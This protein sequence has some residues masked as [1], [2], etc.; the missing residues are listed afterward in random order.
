MA[1]QARYLIRTKINIFTVIFQERAGFCYIA[2]APSVTQHCRSQTGADRRKLNDLE[3]GSAPLMRGGGPKKISSQLKKPLLDPSTQHM[4]DLHQVAQLV[5]TA[6][7]PSAL[8]ARV[9][10]VWNWDWSTPAEVLLNKSSS[11]SLASNSSAQPTSFTPC[12]LSL[13]LRL[14][15]A[16]SIN[17]A[18][19]AALS[20]SKPQA[21]Q[22]ESHAPAVPAFS[23]FNLVFSAPSSQPGEPLSLN[24]LL[25]MLDKFNALHIE[26]DHFNDSL[27]EYTINL[28]IFPRLASLRI[29]IPD[30]HMLSKLRFSARNR[31]PSI[32]ALTISSI[33]D[34]PDFSLTLLDFT[35]STVVRTFLDQS[36]IPCLNLRNLNLDLPLISNLAPSLANIRFLDLSQ[37]CISSFPLALDQLP[38][39]TALSLASNRLTSF[40]VGGNDTQNSNVSFKCLSHLSLSSNSIEVIA[41]FSDKRIFPVLRALDLR[42]NNLDDVLQLKGCS[43]IESL[44]E[45]L[46][47]GNP[48]A[49][50]DSHRLNIFTYFG[51]RATLLK[52]DGQTPTQ[53]E[54]KEILASLTNAAS[55]SSA[56]RVNVKST[57]LHTARV[58]PSDVESPTSKLLQHQPQQPRQKKPTGPGV[59][60][61]KSKKP[62]VAIVEDF[63]VVGM[64][65]LA[66]TSPLPLRSAEGI[67]D[68][69]T[70]YMSPH[71]NIGKLAMYEEDGASEPLDLMMESMYSDERSCTP[72]SEGNAG[73]NP[74]MNLMMRTASTSDNVMLDENANVGD[75]RML[76]KSNE[77]DIPLQ[78]DAVRLYSGSSVSVVG[79]TEGQSDIL[80]ARPVG[81]NV[82]ADRRRAN[83]GKKISRYYDAP[84]DFVF[85]GGG[86]TLSVATSDDEDSLT[87]PLLHYKTNADAGTDRSNSDASLGTDGQRSPVLGSISGTRGDRS[88]GNGGISVGP[89]PLRSMSSGSD[90][91]L[92]SSASADHSRSLSRMDKL[93]RSVAAATVSSGRQSPQLEDST[94]MRRNQ[95]HTAK[96]NFPKMKAMGNPFATAKAA[97]SNDISKPFVE[98][99][100]TTLRQAETA[101]EWQRKMA[102][103]QEIARK[104]TQQ[105]AASISSNSDGVESKLSLS[106]DRSGGGG[107]QEALNFTKSAG[108]TSLNP[109]S[110]LFNSRS[111]TIGINGGVGAASGSGT[112]ALD[113][114][115]P[116]RRVYE[117][118]PTSRIRDD[119][120][121]RSRPVQVTYLEGATV[122]SPAASGTSG[123]ERGSEPGDLNDFGASSG[124]GTTAVSGGSSLPSKRENVVA[125]LNQPLS[126]NLAQP[127]ALRSPPVRPNE[128]NFKGLPRHTIRSGLYGN[129][130]G[131][132]SGMDLAPRLIL[133]RPVTSNITVRRSHQDGSEAGSEMSGTAS[134]YS[135]FQQRQNAANIRT[136]GLS[137][138]G[139]VASSVFSGDSGG[140]SVFSGMTGRTTGSA[141][142]RNYLLNHGSGKPPA[143]ALVFPRAPNVPFLSINN[144]LQLHLK[145]NVF[146]NDQEKI[147]AWVAGSI[148]PQVSPYIEGVAGGATT[149]G[150]R[151]DSA[152]SASSF[153]MGTP[154]VT[155][156]AKL[157]AI[158]ERMQTVERAGYILLTDKAIYL[159]TPTF[160]MPYNPFTGSNRTTPAAAAAA[161]AHLSNVI[162]QVRYDDPTRSLK[163]ARKIPLTH[164]ARVDVG[165]N[166][167]YMGIHF[168]A[169]DEKANSGSANGGGGGA[170]GGGGGGIGVEASLK[171]GGGRAV[172]S[173][174]T[175]KL[176]LSGIRSIVFLTRDRTATSRVLD[177]LVPLL[178]ESTGRLVNSKFNLKGADGKVKVV[179][180]D[181]EWSLAALRSKVLLKQTVAT[182]NGRGGFKNVV[183]NQ[184]D[185]DGRI[186]WRD[187]VAK[188]NGVEMEPP[189]KKSWLSGIL[190]NGFTG[191]S[192]NSVAAEPVQSLQ[193]T[194]EILNEDDLDK[195]TTNAV[196]LDK[197][198]FEFLKLYLLV[199]WIVPHKQAPPTATKSK[200][201]PSVTVTVNSVTLVAT[202]E[203]IYLT[204][205]RFDAWPPPLFPLSTRPAAHVNSPFLEHAAA[206]AAAKQRGLN[207]A[208]RPP[209]PDP[210]QG[211]LAPEIN[212][213]SPPL[214]V[215]RVCDLVRCERWKTWR[216]KLGPHVTQVEEAPPLEQNIA[217]LVQNGAIGIVRAVE[218]EWPIG[219]GS[220]SSSSSSSVSLEDKKARAGATSGWEWWVRVVFKDCESAEGQ[221]NSASSDTPGPSSNASSSSMAGERTGS[222]GRHDSAAPKEYFWDLVFSTL[223]AANEFLEFVK[224]VR[225]VKPVHET[226]EMAISNGFASEEEEEK[227]VGTNEGANA[228]EPFAADFPAAKEEFE[229][230]EFARDSRLFDRVAWDGVGLVIGD[231]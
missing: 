197:V 228:R 69:V 214:R 164:L 123:S 39:L 219:G 136:S 28:A 173:E 165:P 112:A 54:Q 16:I 163:L 201:P 128:M 96:P 38:C 1:W 205:E 218:G 74:F 84:T 71:K 224:D 118:E 104:E 152:S 67:D 13:P 181:V 176:P 31:S 124:S 146:A 4:D 92:P 159:F 77:D 229:E 6:I 29:S 33:R 210:F 157:S 132:E 70:P 21:T 141:S 178:Y 172:G 135:S 95:P 36:A 9:D 222:S 202:A 211:L 131:G 167:Q 204:N 110:R 42:H 114:V 166:R 125:P 227:E 195:A 2:T 215:G 26:C 78:L 7:Q 98:F 225:G 113:T 12:P 43:V 66:E 133:A 40:S 155:P 171:V 143:S 162:A 134:V 91:L 126:R 199:G 207:N 161:N 100:S 111:A 122:F 177:N 121:V 82:A 17:P 191:S 76:E 24:T 213:Y 59:K 226:E 15:H 62:A 57:A 35:N 107:F 144:S 220:S 5:R 188:R 47:Y 85:G 97:I 8:P 87:S 23:L 55:T 223:D 156:D 137:R 154:K 11:E 198:N 83:E 106:A 52:L 80:I 145:F 183:F 75:A 88:L 150:R 175:K 93:E 187:V 10:G 120:S 22:S 50:Q 168:L 151:R 30:A 63:P 231:D 102:H 105:L 72:V 101:L 127:Q 221:P 32:R 139:G 192:S 203:Y 217:T 160:P 73:A 89:S 53:R 60:R 99:T 48:V 51:A 65:S 185:I 169:N 25:S 129:G 138:G 212:Q 115:G 56:T 86:D 19:D 109:A 103:V 79:D 20:Q 140:Y 68:Q 182:A 27:Q 196:V 189:E 117:F 142:I 34:T 61:K 90:A 14:I 206:V 49:Q 44:T 193:R 116:Y 45:V 179:N 153:L 174:S 147:L 149:S 94:F 148:V 108:D 186:D 81:L 216:W 130:E 230:I 180:Q 119:E 158:K 200:I 18:L 3:C 194:S 209:P 46:V 64:D 37:N 170:S 190:N 58:K 208:P 41:D 184:V